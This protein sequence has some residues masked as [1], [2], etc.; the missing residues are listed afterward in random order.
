MIAC[1]KEDPKV[2]QENSL[3]GKWKHTQTSS[4]GTVTQVDA[5]AA[6]I[7]AYAKDGV[8]TI[9]ESQT[10]GCKLVTTHT[11]SF[12]S[13][14]SVSLDS[15]NELSQSGCEKM[16]VTSEIIDIAFAKLKKEF[17]PLVFEYSINE[18]KL[19]LKS[20]KTCKKSDGTSDFVH[21]IYTRQ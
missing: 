4:C 10:I 9:T 11:A 20:D 8:V 17:K 6:Q 15:I 13:A 3:I 14:N 7:L 1:G 21:S 2:A 16:G 19:D 12:P 18:N 5:T